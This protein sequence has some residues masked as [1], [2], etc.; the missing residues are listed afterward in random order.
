MVTHRLDEA[1]MGQ[2]DQIIVMKDGQ[3]RETGTFQDLMNAKEFFYS[4]Y[5]LAS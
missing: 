2:Y 4:L 1:L 3:I 5:T